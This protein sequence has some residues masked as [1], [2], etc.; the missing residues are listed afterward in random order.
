MGR[1]PASVPTDPILHELVHHICAISAVNVAVQYRWLELM[2]A[3]LSSPLFFASNIRDERLMVTATGLAAIEDVLQ[4]VAEGLAHFAEFDC[5]MPD[6]ERFQRAGFS[7]LDALSICLF[8]L[9]EANISHVSDFARLSRREKLLPSAIERRTGVLCHPMFPASANDAYLLGYML[10]K[11]IMDRIPRDL[12]DIRP[13]DAFRF[14]LYYVYEDWVLAGLIATPGPVHVEAI[15]QRLE[16]RFRALLQSDV[17]SRIRDFKQDMVQREQRGMLPRGPEEREHGPFVGIGLTEGEVLTGMALTKRFYD[18][19]I[20]PRAPLTGGMPFLD[21]L[22]THP[23]YLRM[24]EPL[25]RSPERDGFFQRHPGDQGSE[26]RELDFV[27]EVAMSK[28]ALGTAIDMAVEYKVDMAGGFYIRHSPDSAWSVSL[29]SP[30][31]QELA[32]T[33]GIGRLVGVF[34]SRQFPWAMY[35]NLFVG[36]EL[37]ALWCN[38]CGDDEDYRLEQREIAQIVSTELQFEQASRLTLIELGEHLSDDLALWRRD[39]ATATTAKAIR[40]ILGDAGWGGAFRDK[41]RNDFGLRNILR[42]GSLV[43][44]LASVGLC[45]AFTVSRAE[46]EQLMADADHDLGALIRACDECESAT[47]LR[48]LEHDERTVRARI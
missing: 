12:T 2:R 45:N 11:V 31:G 24:V 5:S 13:A 35:C 26:V 28:R 21:V 37:V 29:P 36:I 30:K 25:P 3:S 18:T 44:S 43:S 47:G 40:Q 9:R 32:G 4:P 46:I 7:S 19:A 17:E 23:R 39:N 1:L 6:V 48:L 34:M 10:I 33:Q 15:I 8:R 14:L 22:N 27:L 38:V 20:G 41:P 16:S 42:S